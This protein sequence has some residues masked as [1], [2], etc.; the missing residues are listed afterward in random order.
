[1]WE[2][3]GKS[4]PTSQRDVLQP[5]AAQV[6]DC[7]R[8]AS[9]EPKRPVG[10]PRKRPKSSEEAAKAAKASKAAAARNTAENIQKKRD[11]AAATQAEQR[12]YTKYTQEQ[13]VLALQCYDLQGDGEAA[14]RHI[15]SH[16]SLS[17]PVATVSS[18]ARAIRRWVQQGLSTAHLTDAEQA[19]LG[20]GRKRNLPAELMVKIK[21]EITRL[22]RA[23]LAQA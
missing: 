14:A 5:V 9:P 18:L 17:F 20:P 10:R 1:M 11:A 16:Y 19:A 15:L 7:P 23:L 12:V 13:K 3:W 6:T 2:S 22:V 8:A 21:R 4:K